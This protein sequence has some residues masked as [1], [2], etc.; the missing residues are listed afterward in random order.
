MVYSEILN[1]ERN[2][3]MHLFNNQ[4]RYFAQAL[5]IESSKVVADAV[6]TGGKVTA[7]AAV[8]TAKLPVNAAKAT[9][10]LAAEVRVARQT[11]AAWKQYESK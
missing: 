6:V 5:V 3:V 2:A 10:D 11:K 8:V 4:A 7:K 1:A 9:K